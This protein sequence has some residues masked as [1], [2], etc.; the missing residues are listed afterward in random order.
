MSNL[1]RFKVEERIKLS[2]LK[3]R[4]NAVIVSEELGL[5]LDYVRR[6]S[7]KLRKKESRDVSILISNTLMEHIFAGYRSRTELLT[8]MLNKLRGREQLWVSICC[9]QPTR[10]DI[11]PEGVSVQ[12]CLKCGLPCQVKLLDRN[13]IFALE[14]NIIEQLRE[15]DDALIRFAERMGYTNKEPT[16]PAQV[17][18]NYN[19]HL[20]NNTP[21]PQVTLEGEVVQAVSEMLPTDR[22][23]L[24]KSLEARILQGEEESAPQPDGGQDGESPQGSDS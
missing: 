24:R 16:P 19:L 10:I 9:S 14:Q 23:K 1:E 20:H 17:Q 18:K 11:G 2:L 21:Q 4:G 8:E 22:E 12:V 13:G 3:H 7:F 6:V 5:D 15:E